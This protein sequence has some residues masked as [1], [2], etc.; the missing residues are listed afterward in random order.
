MQ[1]ESGRL[2]A[3]QVENAKPDSGKQWAVIPDGG[4]LY[5]Q[6][7]LNKHGEINRS[8]LF[9]YQLD[10]QRREMGL[11]SLSDR[12]L[13]KARARAREL[14][15]GLL[16][17][18]DPL[19]I[20]EQAK[21]ERLAAR[22]QEAKAVTFKECAKGY[23][24]SHADGWRSAKHT[25]QWSASVEDHAFPVLG[26][27]AVGDITTAHVIKVLEPIWKAKPETAS[28][29]RGRIERILDWAKVR[30]YR[31]GE[32]P[33]RWRGHLAE[34]FPAKGKVRKVKHHAA[35][36][37]EDVPAFMA[38]LRARDSIPARAT[39]FTVLTAARTGEIINAKWD[40][41]DLKAKTWTIPAERMK[42]GAK[43]RVPLSARALAIVKEMEAKRRGD[44]VFAGQ[45]GAP[46]WDQTL[47][48]TV[49]QIG[50]HATMHGMRATFR[51]W[52]DE[53]TGYPHHVVEQALAH[54]IPSAVEKAYRRGDLFEKR[55][56]LMQQW[57][58]FCAKP[59]AK[60]VRDNVVTMRKGT[61]HA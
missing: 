7:T 20:K 46:L 58:D 60:P 22:A 61:A 5:L 4:N 48:Q 45:G 10:G 52:C 55:R 16:D 44:L 21:A 43:H 1:R 41:F 8:W 31:D 32:N 51:T 28:R 33:A 30:E 57:A 40:E 18:V 26:N 36:A 50:G 13:A 37:Y 47:A 9:K 59:A 15:E 6:V 25:K 38:A 35:M 49:K 3:K 14:R 39:E 19:A 27:L 54:A 34:L 53:Q 2:T 23:V 11:G 42:A 24:A 17:G 12:P 29:I 56:K